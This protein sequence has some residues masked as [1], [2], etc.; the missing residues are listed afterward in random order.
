MNAAERFYEQ[1]QR[2][3]KRLQDTC[4]HEHLTDWMEEW[5]APKR[6]CQVCLGEFLEGELKE[7]DGRSLP[8]GEW[9]CEA[10]YSGELSRAREKQEQSRE[11]H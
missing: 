3:L 10:C 4:P 8:L 6:R 5:W 2:E 9:Y 7:G 1:Y 11:K